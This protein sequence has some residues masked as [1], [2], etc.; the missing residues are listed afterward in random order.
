MIARAVIAVAGLVGAA[1]AGAALV[2]E[3]LLAAQAGVIWELPAW[4]SWL[5]SDSG[6]I[7]P[8]VAGVVAALAAIVCGAA[9]LRLLRRRSSGV[10]RLDLGEPNAAVVVEAATLDRLLAEVLHRQLPVLHAVKVVLC[11]TGHAYSARVLVQLRGCCDLLGLRTQVAA[12]VRR[13]LRRATGLDLTRVDLDVEKLDV[14]GG[15]G[16]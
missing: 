1:I 4:T 15:G 9:A 7:R 10:R 11:T 12:V 8:T 6:W 3:V 2:R 5:V 16:A 13:E 14:K